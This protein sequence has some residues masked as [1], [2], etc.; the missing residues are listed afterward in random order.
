MTLNQ[1][2]WTFCD[3][4]AVMSSLLQPLALINALQKKEERQF[5]SVFDYIPHA[6]GHLKR[7]PLISHFAFLYFFFVLL[8]FCFNVLE[9][10]RY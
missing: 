2:L 7:F 3:C 5:S 6:P 8:F 10:E 9:T 1:A 4:M